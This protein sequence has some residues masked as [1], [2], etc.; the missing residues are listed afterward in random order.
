MEYELG[1]CDIPIELDVLKILGDTPARKCLDLQLH[2][3][4]M[5]EIADETGLSLSSIG[6][7]L[8]RTKNSL[9][10][11]LLTDKEIYKIYA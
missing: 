7:T 9:R 8:H 6:T 10:K 2:G 1:K 5:K 3:A 4:S 11:Y